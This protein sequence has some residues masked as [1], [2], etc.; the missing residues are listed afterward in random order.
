MVTYRHTE[1]ALIYS[2]NTI[3]PVTGATGTSAKDCMC[4]L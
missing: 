4:E 3:D 2:R 1:Y